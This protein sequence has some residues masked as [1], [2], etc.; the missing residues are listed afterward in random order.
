MGGRQAWRGGR[1][2][3]LVE[4]GKLDSALSCLLQRSAHV[5]GISMKRHRGNLRIRALGAPC[6]AFLTLLPSCTVLPRDDVTRG[7]RG[8]RRDGRRRS[9]TSP[10]CHAP[11]MPPQMLLARRCAWLCA[12]GYKGRAPS[13]ASG[14]LAPWRGRTCVPFHS[15]LF[16]LSY[17]IAVTPAC[18]ASRYYYLGATRCPR[19]ARNGG[20]GGTQ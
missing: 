9:L 6:P 10:C 19:E 7:T 8:R 18:R 1:N 14:L 11:A 4:N 17:R 3:G 15:F 20:G 16:L 12:V 5:R 13:I 2:G